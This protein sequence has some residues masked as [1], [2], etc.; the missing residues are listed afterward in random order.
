L[1]ILPQFVSSQLNNGSRSKVYYDQYTGW[2]ISGGLGATYQNR[3]RSEVD[4][5]AGFAG[6]LTIGKD[7]WK[8]DDFF[9][10]GLRYRYLSGETLG[11][12]TFETLGFNT[13]ADSIGLAQNDR[14]NG[15]GGAILNYADSLGIIADNYKTRLRDHSLEFVLHFNKLRQQTGI[16]LNG[17][18]GAGVTFYRAK[19]NQLDEAGNQYEY[20][21]TDDYSLGFFNDF[22]DESFETYVDNVSGQEATFMPSLGFEVGFQ[23]S[24]SWALTYTHRHTWTRTNDFDGE[25]YVAGGISDLNDSYWYS[26]LTLRWHIHKPGRSN[27]NI[28]NTNN[29][30]TNNTVITP[31]RRRPD[32]RITDPYS[33][34]HTVNTWI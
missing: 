13:F 12:N 15:N 26:G 27:T 30:T 16:I 34:P 32:V 33:N 23:L 1:I 10:W 24:R 29:N 11:F 9:G 18:A 17:F 3:R 5:Y 14:F 21:A 28:Y 22:R 31:T 25:R 20:S 4:R 8:Q 6:S 2:N 7:W 19:T